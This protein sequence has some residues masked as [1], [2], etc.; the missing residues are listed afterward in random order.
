MTR[1]SLARLVLNSWLVPRCSIQPGLGGWLKALRTDSEVEYYNA[2]SVAL[3]CM[4]DLTRLIS[5][6]D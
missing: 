3:L 5:S 1:L 6:L 4:M 2:D